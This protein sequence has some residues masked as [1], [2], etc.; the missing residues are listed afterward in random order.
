MKNLPTYFAGSI[1]DLKPLRSLVTLSGDSEV[2]IE[3]CRRILEC[4][5]IK[6]SVLSH[7]Y[8]FDIWG[9]QLTVTSFANGSAAVHGKIQSVSIARKRT[10][11][12]EKADSI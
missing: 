2:L 3:S 5:D 10:V 12:G 8:I 7:G 9:S 1:R 6:C 11:S 4:N